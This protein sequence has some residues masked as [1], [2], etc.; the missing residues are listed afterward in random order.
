MSYDP[1]IVQVVA[2]LSLIDL[3]DCQLSLCI[4]LGKKMNRYITYGKQNMSTWK[5]H[6]HL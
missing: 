2:G 1:K 5:D 6:T 3:E 4:V